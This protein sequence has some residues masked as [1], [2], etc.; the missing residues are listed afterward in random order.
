MPRSLDICF[1]QRSPVH[2][3]RMHDIPNRDTHLYAPHNNNRSAALWADHRWKAD[4]LES[5]TRIRTFIPYIGT[6]PPGMAHPRAAWVRLKWLRT[7]IGR[8]RS[9]L[10]TQMR[11]VPSCS[12]WVWRRRTDRW[13]CCPSLPNPS[14]SLWGAMAWWFW[15]TR[16]SNDCWTPA[17]RSSE[18][19]QW[20]ERTAHTMKKKLS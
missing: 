8:F 15:M 3:M 19:L 10:L 5:T 1:T 20:L 9:C 4:W 16:N 6:H 18:A 11:Y 12:L 2:G 14:T 13:P 7:C 17:P